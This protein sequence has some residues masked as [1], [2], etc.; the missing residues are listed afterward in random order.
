MDNVFYL[1][2]ANS[3]CI[4]GICLTKKNNSVSIITDRVGFS[5]LNESNSEEE[6]S[7]DS[8]KLVDRL[9]NFLAQQHWKDHAITFLLPAE[10]VTF[11]KI[12]FPFH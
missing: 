6:I 3:S 5:E 11:R 10:D 4:E 12:T 2:S 9:D 1:L 8:K 7:P